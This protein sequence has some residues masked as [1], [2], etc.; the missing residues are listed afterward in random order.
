MCLSVQRAPVALQQ[1]DIRP[2]ALQTPSLVASSDTTSGGRKWAIRILQEC[3]LVNYS[4][5]VFSRTGLSCFSENRGKKRIWIFIFPEKENTENLPKT[6]KN[7]MRIY[8]EHR[9][10]PGLWWDVTT[11]FGFCINFWVFGDF[12]NVM[13]HLATLHL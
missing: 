8:L 10:I 7:T 12:S 9:E 3:F 1:P 11:T 13:R 2:E 6:I 5:C 4:F